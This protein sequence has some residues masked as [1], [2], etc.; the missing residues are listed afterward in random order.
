MGLSQERNDP[1]D[2]QGLSGA[3]WSGLAVSRLRLRFLLTTVARIG[4]RLVFGMDETLER[5]RGEK[6]TATG[7]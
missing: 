3:S 4:E 2:H 6:I 1:K 5:R 7:S